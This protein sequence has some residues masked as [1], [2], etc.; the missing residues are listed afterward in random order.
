MPPLKVFKVGDLPPEA[1]REAN[2]VY[3]V[4][5]AGAPDFRMFVTTYTDG[6]LP[7]NTREIFYPSAGGVDIRAALGEASFEKELAGPIG[8]SRT[9]EW[10]PY[11]LGCR[12]QIGGFTPTQNRVYG[13]PFRPLSNGTPTDMAAAIYALGTQ[14][15]DAWQR[16]AI[17]EGT[18][19]A[20]QMPRY[21]NYTRLWQS[22]PILHGLGHIQAA[23]TG[24][25]AFDPG[26][27]YMLCWGTTATGSK[28]RY[29]RIMPLL[30]Q[31]QF[32]AHSTGTGSHWRTTVYSYRNSQ[33][34]VLEGTTDFAAAYEP[35]WFSDITS[36]LN[37]HYHVPMFRIA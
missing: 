3:L 30:D 34:S 9:Y 20:G 36:S 7:P 5:Q 17:Y 19:V 22:A 28:V 11:M 29:T 16:F 23:I 25:P 13:F 2:A 37:Y 4:G 26:K 15:T 31:A 24:M 12:W 32:F 35:N 27:F 8:T 10:T 21:W 33:K 18:P 6:G 14:T 1:S